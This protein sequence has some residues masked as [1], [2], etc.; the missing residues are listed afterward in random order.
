MVSSS[1]REAIER[2]PFVLCSLRWLWA[3]LGM[4]FG[5]M[6][7]APSLR[8]L[9]E[10]LGGCMPGTC[11]LVVHTSAPNFCITSVV[12]SWHACPTSVEKTYQLFTSKLA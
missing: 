4:L 11:V 5:W 1:F 8:R 6:L 10:I 12:C 3:G 7:F 2:S 9:S